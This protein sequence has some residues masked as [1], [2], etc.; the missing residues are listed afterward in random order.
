MQKLGVFSKEI[1]GHRKHGMDLGRRSRYYNI[2][3]RRNDCAV[4][5]IEAIYSYGNLKRTEQN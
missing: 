3:L 1:D 5:S 4:D 2:V